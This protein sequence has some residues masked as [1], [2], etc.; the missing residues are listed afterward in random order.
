MDKWELERLLEDIIKNSGNTSRTRVEAIR[1][2]AALKGFIP[3]VFSITA[4]AADE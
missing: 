4:V 2:L 3:P 1:I